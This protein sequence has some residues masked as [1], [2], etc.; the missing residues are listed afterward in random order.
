MRKNRKGHQ[1]RKT[2]GLT[3]LFR[4]LEVYWELPSAQWVSRQTDDPYYPNGKSET[5]VWELQQAEDKKEIPK[6]KTRLQTI[7][8]NSYQLMAG[9]FQQTRP[10]GAVEGTHTKN[11]S[12]QNRTSMA[13][14]YSTCLKFSVLTIKVSTL[15]KGTNYLNDM[16][17]TVY[18]EKW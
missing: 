5:D 1:V 6:N 17:V 8:Q 11:E 9:L 3:I 2:L 13:L 10:A 7:G 18:A 15:R 12:L 4:Q 16:F 14:W